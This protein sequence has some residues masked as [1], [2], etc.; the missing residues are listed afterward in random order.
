MSACICCYWT[1]TQR[2]RPFQW[3][4][5]TQNWVL[6]PKLVRVETRLS[7]RASSTGRSI[8]SAFFTNQH[9][10]DTIAQQ[11]TMVLLI[12]LIGS[13]SSLCRYLTSAISYWRG[14]GHTHTSLIDYWRD[15]LH[16]KHFLVTQ[17]ITD[18][19]CAR[20]ARFWLFRAAVLHGY[21][22]VVEQRMLV[23]K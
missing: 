7:F 16:T 15:G 11:T 12:M 19:H 10:N 21:S 1:M 8:W 13:P 18:G 2:S 20:E 3:N 5:Y 17:T 23:I 14:R 4:T 6:E 9:Q 22:E